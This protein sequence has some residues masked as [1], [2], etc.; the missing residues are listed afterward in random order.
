MA[1]TRPGADSQYAIAGLD[2]EHRPLYGDKTKRDGSPDIWLAPKAP[3]GKEN[4]WIQ[5]IP[6]KCWFIILWAYGTLEPW[7]D[8]TWRRVN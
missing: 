8:K 5:T 6:G 7:I 4:R 3:K 1:L 2:V